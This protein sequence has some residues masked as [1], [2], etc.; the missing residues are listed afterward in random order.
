MLS[1]IKFIFT[2]K[3]IRDKILFVIGILFLFRV[4]STIPIPGVDVAR[5]E[6]FLSNSQLFG[7]LNIFSAGGIST[8]SL[9]MLGVGPYITASIIMQLMTVLSPKVKAMYKEEGEIGRRKFTQYS[10]YLTIPLAIAQAIGLL[11]LLQRQGILADTGTFAMVS[12]V[13]IVTAGSMLLMWLGELVSEKGIGQGVSI[14]IFAGIVATLPRIV[15]QTLSTIVIP[16]D[17]P[18]IAAIVIGTVVV[19]AG[20]IFI[21]EAERK[22]PITYAKQVRGMSGSTAGGNTYIPLRLNQAGVIPIIFALSLF[23][24][25]QVLAS[26]G[27]TSTNSI[28][29]S[30][31]SGMTWFFQNEWL[32]SGVYFLLVFG[33]TYMYT[34]ITF[35]PNDVA[36]NLQKGGAFIPGIRP[37]EPTAEYLSTVL[38]RVTFAGA[39]FL[40]IMAVLPLLVQSATGLQQVAIGGTSLLIAVSVVLD[41]IKKI[42][43]Q[44]SM[45]EY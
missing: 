24:F 25:P 40:G 1:K 8:L 17:I 29:Q 6:Q 33:F 7:I 38:T 5:L 41:M 27:A 19:T 35:E 4:L 14:L 43:A 10:R 20:V 45:R 44:I 32:Y 9:V 28:I 30:I 37:G 42:D 11:V 2:E 23:T 34:A 15:A 39:F 3:S 36:D 13:L 16:Q 26:L 18:T 31:S 21:T 12:N 22:V